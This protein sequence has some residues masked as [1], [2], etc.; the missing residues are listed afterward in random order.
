MRYR[1]GKGL[2]LLIGSLQL[3][4]AFFDPQLQLVRMV[5]DATKQPSLGDRDRKLRRQ[6]PRSPPKLIAP[7]SSPPA[8]IGIT[9]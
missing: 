4:R 9:M 3:G 2:E 1:I 8:I 7:I 6:G 5:L